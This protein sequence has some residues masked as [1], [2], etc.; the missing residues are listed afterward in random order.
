MLIILARKNEVT[1]WQQPA[2][3]SIHA[4]RSRKRVRVT[5]PRQ[6]NA[7][8]AAGIRVLSSAIVSNNN[9]I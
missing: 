9:S 2:G 3:L 7:E 6:L 1:G 4:S 8:M 5:P